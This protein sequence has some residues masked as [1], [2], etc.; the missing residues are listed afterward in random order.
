MIDKIDKIDKFIMDNLPTFCWG[1][2]CGM[3]VTLLR[4]T[5]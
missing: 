3:A 2:L 4:F 5:A 1:F